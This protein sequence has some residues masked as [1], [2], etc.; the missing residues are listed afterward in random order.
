MNTSF[1]LHLF[2]KWEL[3]LKTTGVITLMT[4]H[5]PPPL[6]YQKNKKQT[7]KPSKQTGA[8]GRYGQ[9]H[10]MLQGQTMHTDL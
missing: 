9:M 8:H 6:T 5:A 1:L 4:T 2:S 3:A 10:V 7:K